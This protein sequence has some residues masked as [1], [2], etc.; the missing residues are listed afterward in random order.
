VMFRA[1]TN[2]RPSHLAD[3][4]L[5]DFAGLAAIASGLAPADRENSLQLSAER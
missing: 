4:E 1:L 3:P 5:F 2:V